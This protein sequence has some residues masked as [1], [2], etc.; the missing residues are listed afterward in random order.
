MPIPTIAAVV[1]M[2][3]KS[4]RVPGKNYRLLNGRPLYHYIIDSL[5]VCKYVNQVLI[6]TDSPWIMDDAQKHFPSVLLH[7][8][9]AH[10]R[11][12]HLSMNLVLENSI[13]Q[14]AAEYYLQTHSTNPLIRA[15]T[16]DAAIFEYFENESAYDSLFTV[17]RIQ[18]RLW[19]AA[20]RPLNHDPGVLLRTQDLTP[21]FEENSCLYLFSGSRFL[22]TGNRIGQRPH[23]F[24]I[25][26]LEA[27]DI[28]EESDFKL[29]EFLIKEREK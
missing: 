20:A 4:E 10:L 29:A 9:P 3:H 18:T 1:P 5:L 14:V 23:L 27:I 19:D 11:E 25:D 22:A 2:R 24:E 12:D 26:A 16:I 6:D 17:T 21:V 28:D 7:E 15:E 8:R 13:R